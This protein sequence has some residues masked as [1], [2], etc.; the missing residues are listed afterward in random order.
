[1]QFA[2]A[3][4]QSVLI[5]DVDRDSLILTTLADLLVNERRWSVRRPLCK[6]FLI[7]DAILARQVEIEGGFFGS[8]DQAAADASCARSPKDSLGE[9]SGVFTASKGFSLSVLTGPV[10]RAAMQHGL[11]MYRLPKASARFMPIRLAS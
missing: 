1:V 3:S 8:G 4:L 5:A 6:D 9:S 11:M 10:P 7:H 2:G